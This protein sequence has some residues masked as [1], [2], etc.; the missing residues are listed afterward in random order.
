MEKTLE[1]ILDALPNHVLLDGVKEQFLNLQ[2]LHD[3]DQLVYQVSLLYCVWSEV[4]KN[5]T[6]LNELSQYVEK[7][8][9]NVREGIKESGEIQKANPDLYF[10]I[11]DS[12]SSY[13]PIEQQTLYKNLVKLFNVGQYRNFVDGLFCLSMISSSF[14]SVILKRR[15]DALLKGIEHNYEYLEEKYPRGFIKRYGN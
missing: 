3:F 15:I 13:M 6:S 14:P 7:I 2:E 10:T 12:F 1:Q 4:E 5:N 11:V 8:T 9:A